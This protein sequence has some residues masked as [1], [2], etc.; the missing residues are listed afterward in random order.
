MNPM[1]EEEKKEKT[2]LTAR[3][4]GNPW[5]LS[6]FVLVVLAVVLLV[7]SIGGF[8]FTGNAISAAEAGNILLNLYQSGGV[9]GLSIDSVKEVSGLYEVNLLYQGG[10]VPVY[11]TKDGKYAGSL[12]PT[13][14]SSADTGTGSSTGSVEVSEDDDAVLGNANAPVTIIELSDYQCIFCRKFWTETLP[15]IKKNYIDT[16]KVKLVYR[17]LPIASLH[18]MAQAS[19]EAA[20]CV[21]EKGG[22]SSYFKYHDKVFGE[23]NILDSGNRNGPVTQTV[24][25]TENDL[26]KWAKDLGYDIASCLDSGK[27]FDEVQKD[28]ADGQAAGFSGTPQF[29]VNG[30]PLPAGAQPYSVFEQFIEGELAA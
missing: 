12:S 21:R 18:P 25:Y 14:G 15:L 16:G 2:D 26:K 29:L 17:D 5:I 8:S 23:Q 27:Y 9:T 22:D 19:A 4:R 10:I 6:T 20:E 13:S 3:L 11:V 7:G 1:E 30:K 24:T 28:M